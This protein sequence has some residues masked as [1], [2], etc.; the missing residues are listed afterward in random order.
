VNNASVR[1]HRARQ[2]LARRVRAVCG[3]CADRKCADCSCPPPAGGDKSSSRRRQ[4]RK[5]VRS[6]GGVRPYPRA[7]D[8][9]SLGDHRSGL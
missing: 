9:R 6:G 1:L 5:I 3:A 4:R 7:S 8:R 2:A